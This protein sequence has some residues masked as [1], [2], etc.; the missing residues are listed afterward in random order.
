MDS[1]Y[2]VIKNVTQLIWKKVEQPIWNESR[3]RIEKLLS[4][5]LGAILYNNVT[6]LYLR[7]LKSFLE[8]YLIFRK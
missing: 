6:P 2:S 4:S 5:N 7:R 8:R 3:R 1:E